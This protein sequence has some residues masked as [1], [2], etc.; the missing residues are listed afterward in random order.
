L[1]CVG[2]F[3]LGY[4]KQNPSFP[5][6]AINPDKLGPQPYAPDPTAVAPYWARDGSYLVYRRLRQDVPAF[7]RFVA[8]Q[9]EKLAQQP[10]FT[11][12]T[13]EKLAALLVGRWKSG[14]PLMRTPQS[15]DTKLGATS[16]ANND[17]GYGGNVDDPGDGFPFTAADPNGTLCP[18]AAHI[19]KVNPRD[20]NTDQGPSPGTLKHRILRRGLPFGPPL[21]LNATEDTGKE[22][23]GLLF[24]SYQASIANQFEFLCQKWTN[25]P[26][27]PSLIG[28]MGFDMLIGQNNQGTPPRVRFCVLRSISVPDVTISTQGFDPMDWVIPT[29]G[30]YFFAPSLS[31]IRNVLCSS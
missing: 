12:M 16:P 9:A 24:L 28:T 14:A 10:G 26:D 6:L 31:A 27:K 18:I 30:G 3:V 25:Q 8:T 2:E 1:V 21:P 22:E 17:F 15:D 20:V 11:D 5:R 13:P 23:R 4:G 7:N 19:R 29:G